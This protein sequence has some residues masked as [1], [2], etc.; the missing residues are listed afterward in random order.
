MFVSAFHTISNFQ[1]LLLALHEL[2][3]GEEDGLSVRQEK[4]GR[5]KRRK[6]GEKKKDMKEIC[7]AIDDTAGMSEK[8]SLM[9]E[10]I[11]K[12]FKTGTIKEAFSSLE[13]I[14]REVSLMVLKQAFPNHA[15][16]IRKISK[17]PLSKFK[18]SSE[19][20]NYLDAVIKSGIAADID[21]GVV[22]LVGNT[23]VGKSSLANTLKAFIE[24]P[25]QKPTPILAGKGKYKD[26][27]ETQVMEVYNEV[28]FQQN[29]GQS[30]KL[31]DETK[32]GPILVDFVEDTEK[33]QD[34]RKK[35]KIRL[36]DMGGHQEQR[37]KKR[38]K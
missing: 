27:I 16:E 31:T 11:R 32:D 23:G 19:I 1:C 37:W 34:R 2:G 38:K 17:L 33:V 29:Q 15:K 24:N 25:S 14:E 20:G 18:T 8:E 21:R 5:R 3:I 4:E 22:F 10:T 6:E 28:T 9:Y 7:E 35:V 26:L 36:I 30:L 13:G 12:E